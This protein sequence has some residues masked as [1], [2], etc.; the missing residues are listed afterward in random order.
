MVVCRATYDPQMRVM[1]PV[2]EC[3]SYLSHGRKNLD[4][5]EE[6]A[7]MLAP[8]GSN[9][10]P[11]SSR[12][13]DQQRTSAKSRSFSMATSR[14]TDHKPKRECSGAEIAYEGAVNLPPLEGTAANFRLAAAAR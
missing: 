6:I 13:L 1:F 2:R 5:M 3:S 4:D 9:G 14:N 11:V 10:R 8:R 12:P 7:W